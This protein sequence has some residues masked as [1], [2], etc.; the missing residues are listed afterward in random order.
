MT[1][2]SCHQPSTWEGNPWRPFCSEQCQMTDL[3]AWAA[4]R[5]RIPGSTLLMDASLPESF[6]SEDDTDAQHNREA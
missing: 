4:E 1:C 2:P 5:Y 3:G 6:E